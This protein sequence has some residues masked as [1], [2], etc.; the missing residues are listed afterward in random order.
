M[1]KKIVR[2]TKRTCQNEECAT[3][4]YDLNR[5]DFACPE[6]G[7]DFDHDANV[8]LLRQLHGRPEYASRK[9]ARVLPI[10]DGSEMEG[11]PAGGSVANTDEQIPTPDS[12]DPSEKVT[13]APLD[14]ADGNE[15]QTNTIPL[16][17]A[18]NDNP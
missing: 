5:K 15:A 14:E 9:H 1:S 4:F 2:G 3:S 6:C 8:L 16:S 17:A 18:W 13:D 7:T 10:T 11:V 12:S